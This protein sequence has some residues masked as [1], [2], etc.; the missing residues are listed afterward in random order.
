MKIDR[1]SFLSFLIGGA[2][3]TT[4]SP[5]PWKL[6]DDLSIWTQMWPWTPVP[7]KGEVTYT[8][9]T[10]TLC[11][12]GCGISVK[13]VDNRVVKIE[14]LDGHPVNDGGLCTLGLSGAQLLYGPRRVAGPMKKVNGKFRVVSWEDALAEIADTLAGLRSAGKP[15]QLACIA[16]T[17]RGTLSELMQ[18]FLT[19]YGSPNFI[20]SPSIQDSYELA[21][22][23]MQGVRAL[24]GF[25]IDETDFVLSFGSGVLDGW[26]S[27]VYMFK[28]HSRWQERGGKL[29]QIEPRLSRTAAKADRWVPINPGTEGTLALGIAHVLIKESLYNK[30]FVSSATYGFDQWQRQVLDG[31]GPEIVSK[32]TGV[33]ASVISDLARDFA[34][35][36][37]PLALGGRGQGLIP[38]SLKEIMAVHALNA[39]MGNLGQSGGVTSVPVLEYTD[40]PELEMDETAAE[41]MQQNRIDGAG[42]GRYAQAR[43]LLNRLPAAISAGAEPQLQVLFIAGTNPC[44]SMPG[45]EAFKEALEKVPMVVSFSSYM[46]ETTAMADLVLPNHTYL[47]RYEDV[48]T[49]FGYR[50]PIISLA[51]PVVE[52]L[53]NTRHTGDVIIQL[54]QVLNGTVAAAFP[55]ENYET[56]LAETLADKWDKLEEDGYWVDEDYNAAEVSTAFET[57]SGRFEFVNE[58][59]NA[60]ARY[61]VLKPDGDEAAYPQVLVPFDSMR[62]WAGPVGNTPFVMKTVEDTVLKGDDVL[63]EVNPDTAKALGLKNGGR[64]LLSTPGGEARVRIYAYEGIMPGLVAMPRGLGHTANDRFL[65]GK[66]VNVNSLMGPV[67]DPATGYNAVWGIRAKLTKA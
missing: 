53:L 52:P 60:L 36:R 8:P 67:E 5:L 46:D 27:P 2:A 65:A 37:N 34:K 48:P 61:T 59:I 11:P 47:E 31:Y 63:V 62:L 4:L 35:A 26:G 1:R 10:C 23:M 25:D 56:C 32:V 45:N 12:G 51:Q 28:G 58:D 21:L 41:G 30:E 20:R 38:G 40:W 66:G 15:Q 50:Q 64:A 22:H 55:W 13:K 6:T 54:A 39:M 43:F 18:R 7:E 9:S 33:E 3:G 17:D 57:D 19:A 14:G 44:Y 49:A 42:S 24:P 16:G 29:V